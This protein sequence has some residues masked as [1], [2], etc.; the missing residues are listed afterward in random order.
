MKSGLNPIYH[1]SC[2][3]VSLLCQTASQYI[4]PFIRGNPARI[5]KLSSRCVL[6]IFSIQQ[7][8][9]VFVVL[10]AQYDTWFHSFLQLL[11]LHTVSRRIVTFFLSPQSNCLTIASNQ[12]YSCKI[13]R[14]VIINQQFRRAP[15][16]NILIW[17]PV[18]MVDPRGENYCLSD[19][20]GAVNA[21]GVPRKRHRWRSN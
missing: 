13:L 14:V 15:N 20:A 8:S 4:H 19:F 17:R 7:M 10:S 12:G 16:G 21:M 9:F 18:H 2:A 3:R 11:L 5:H 1:F 6:S